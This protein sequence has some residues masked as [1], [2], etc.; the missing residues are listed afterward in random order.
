M[1][2]RF[3]FCLLVIFTSFFLF[4]EA[5]GIDISLN[6]PPPCLTPSILGTCP[7]AGDLPGYIA[8]LYQFGIGIS[9]VIAVGMIVIGSI[10][11]MISPVID[12]Q[13]QGKSMIT[14]ALWGLV[15]L[16]LSYLILQSINPRLLE[17]QVGGVDDIP[18]ETQRNVQPAAATCKQAEV[19]ACKNGTYP[20][21]TFGRGNFFPSS[22]ADMRAGKKGPAEYYYL[23]YKISNPTIKECKLFK[24]YDVNNIKKDDY[25]DQN[26][27]NQF[28]PC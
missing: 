21:P 24:T 11:R 13:A 12:Q 28:K 17:L 22:T 3:F 23:F 5:R 16:F 25:L 26:F 6:Y 2:Y 8:R 7:D 4:H 1:R 15:L 9:G 18:L 14:S 19:E 10:L 20:G 27:Y